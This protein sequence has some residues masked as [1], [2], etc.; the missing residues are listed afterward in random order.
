MN[1][2]F[3]VTGPTGCGK[4]K[5]AEDLA[6]K[7]KVE[8]V[9][10][11]AF[12][13]YKEIPIVSNQPESSKVAH[14]FLANRSLAEPISAGEFSR[15]SASAFSLNAIWVG[16]GLYLGAALYG[17]DADR[18]KGTP[19]QGEPLHPFKMIVVERDRAEL[20]E[21][22]NQRVDQMIERG[23]LDE[24][25]KIQEMLTQNQILATNHVLKAIGVR[26]MLSV[27]NQE[28]THEKA[29][30]IWKRD[31]RHLAKR[32]WTWLRKFCAPSKQIL[33]LNLSKEKE[34]L[35][36]AEEFFA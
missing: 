17:L 2:T 31:T 4:S 28:M 7:R 13:M 16:T 20:Y 3:V 12:Q 35:K 5:F 26:Q 34:A 32:Q 10:A 21:V 25:K 14:H 1:L 36:Q 29:I 9:N 24:I 15:L 11:D 18:K 27:F 8:I 19:F 33:W 23:A 30:E 6:V 22:L